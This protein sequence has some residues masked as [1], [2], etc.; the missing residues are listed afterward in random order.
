MKLKVE[1]KDK[2]K[3]I[4]IHNIEIGLAALVKH[5]GFAGMAHN[6]AKLNFLQGI[7]CL[8]YHFEFL[9]INNFKL[10]GF[11]EPAIPIYDPTKKG[12][13]SNILGKAIGD[14]LSK[15]IYSA[16]LS[17]HYESAMLING[18]P[19][20]N[21]SRPDLYCMNAN[22]QFAVECKGFSK[23][24]V[25]KNKMNDYKNQSLSGPLPINFSVASVTYGI[26]KN[27]NVRYHDPIIRDLPFNQE[28]NSSLIAEYYQ[29]I[30]T[31]LGISENTETKT[32]R[33]MEFYI[34][35][36][37]NYILNNYQPHKYSFLVT[38]RIHEFLSERQVV[39]D[40]GDDY[41]DNIY[42]DNDGV[43]IKIE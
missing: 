15:K 23:I 12:Q 1:H 5:F 14:F 21:S 39:F 10:M 22:E 20:N 30:I 19:I 7:G 6:S 17:V 34:I 9:D 40:S 27:I 37:Q 16:T 26:F 41:G 35:P 2:S 24:K 25:S 18:Y 42:I 13:F 38:T 11:K 33:G 28:L 8:M 32:I 43:G 36:I 29:S 3:L 31:G 4:H